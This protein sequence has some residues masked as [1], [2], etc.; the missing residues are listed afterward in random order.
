M[1]HRDWLGLKQELPRR[2]QLQLTVVSF[3][4][5]LL[6]WTAISYI[7]WL[8][9]PLIR[10]TAPGSVD[11]FTEDMDL[12]RADF[13]RELAKARAAKLALPEGHRVNPIYLPAPHEVARAFYTAFKTPPRLPN[14]PWLHESLGHSIRTIFLGFV[15][16]S[17]LGLPLGIL[18]G[19][20]RFFAKLQEPFI[21]FFRYLPAPA[22]GALCVAILGIDD[23]PKIAIIFIGTFFQQVLVIANTVR[24]V[25]PALIEAAQTLGATGWT[26]VRRVIIPASVTDVYTDMRIL[27]GWAWTYLIVAEV[28]GTMSGITFFIN[29]QARYRNFDNVY[30][31]IGMIGIIGFSTDLVLAWIGTII[32]PWKRKLRSGRAKWGLLSRIV[33]GAKKPVKPSGD[34]TTEKPGVELHV[35][36]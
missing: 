25:D 24:K 11:Y 4:A 10:V 16:S 30:A 13:E 28:V 9:H 3:L 14:E 21:E 12:P 8:W 33:P 34:P 22:F 5:P 31:A 7:P 6:L 18:C 35:A 15:A 29:Q 26:L 17:I 1:A 20:Y 2:R 23:P 36:P 32:F 19:A 27:L